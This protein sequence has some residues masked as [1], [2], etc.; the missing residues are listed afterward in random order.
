MEVVAAAV[1]A[2]WAGGVCITRV[3]DRKK[4]K[5]ARRMVNDRR[6]FC[7]ALRDF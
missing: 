4:A 2:A 7:R 5:E 6:S 3:E 1:D